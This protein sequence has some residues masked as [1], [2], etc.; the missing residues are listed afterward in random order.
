M[1]NAGNPPSTSSR[2]VVRAIVNAAT[3]EEDPFGSV[4]KDLAIVLKKT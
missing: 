1:L 4:T 2:A 3:K